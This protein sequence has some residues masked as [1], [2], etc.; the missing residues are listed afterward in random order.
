MDSQHSSLS[1][2]DKIIESS[3][4]YVELPCFA[5]PGWCNCCPDPSEMFSAE[6][7]EMSAAN[8]TLLNKENVTPTN[9]GE[10]EIQSE[11]LPAKKKKLSLAKSKNEQPPNDRFNMTIDD[12]SLREATKA[13]CPKNTMS[14]NKWAV[15]NFAEWIEAR[16]KKLGEPQK[17]YR[18]ILFT[19]NAKELSHWLS[20]FVKETRKEDGGEYTPKTLYMLI[21][22][23]Q[24]EMRLHKQSDQVFNVLSDEQFEGFRNVCDH[25]FRRLHQKGVGT[26]IHRTE[27]LTEDDE[28]KLWESG[29]LNVDTPTG[30]FNC[31][32][33]YNGKNF[34]LRGGEEHRNLMLSQFQ[35][36][37][38]VVQQ[39]SVVRYTYT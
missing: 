3:Q 38:V 7:K 12:E 4:H 29:V 27:A 11:T 37:E 25:E 32:F 24:R 26:D 23:L 17:P 18:E 8:L 1:S 10:T 16:R 19:D 6:P 5:P 14:N 33:L 35:R 28:C 31:V 34:C 13:F 15:K 39:K 20:A 30:L 21:A 9:S 22:G 2:I 36:E